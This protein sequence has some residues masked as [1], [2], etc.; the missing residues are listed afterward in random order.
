MDYD[1][2]TSSGQS[3]SLSSQA[4]IAVIHIRVARIYPQNI[5]PMTAKI[6]NGT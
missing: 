2:F 3:F 1:F 6:V 5:I 4:V